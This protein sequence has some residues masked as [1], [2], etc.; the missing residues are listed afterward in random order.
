MIE[1]IVTV[2]GKGIQEP[3][4]VV[5]RVGTPIKDLIEFCGGLKTNA[6]K[7]IIGGPMMGIAQSTLDVPVV[8]T[9]GGI[10]VLTDEEVKEVKPHACIR[11]GKCVDACP[12]KLV[13]SKLGA[14]IEREMF[15][16]IDDY[17][18]ND[19]ME[20]GC[21]VYVCPANRPMV[22]WIKLGKAILRSRKK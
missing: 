13:P 5:A 18:V 17:H 10:L 3:K 16:K 9:T 6:R 2:T 8:K 15:D 1:R 4:N 14:F 19:C 20:C 22:Q 7:I 11:C 12:I 21:C